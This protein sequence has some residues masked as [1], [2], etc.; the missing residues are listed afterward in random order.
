MLKACA[1]HFV[2]VRCSAVPSSLT[3]AGHLVVGHRRGGSGRR[4]EVL[5][6]VLSAVLNNMFLQPN[7]FG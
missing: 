4:E 2:T 6:T 7:T 3:V 5:N 1:M